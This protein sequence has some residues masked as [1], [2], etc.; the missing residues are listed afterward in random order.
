MDKRLTWLLLPRISVDFC[1]KVVNSSVVRLLFV[2]K[3]FILFD[4]MHVVMGYIMCDN[5][6]F[7]I[8][9]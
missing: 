3:Q 9:I 2:W 7:V 1:V 5:S 6:S 4:P 8:V